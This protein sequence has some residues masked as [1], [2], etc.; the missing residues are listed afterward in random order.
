MDD[1]TTTF[2]EARA[3]VDE[4]ASRR[5]WFKFHSPKAVAAALAIE[6]AELQQVFLWLDDD[7]CEAVEYNTVDAADE[8]ADVTIYCLNMARALGVDLAAAIERKMTKNARK[9]PAL[10]DRDA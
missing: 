2:A 4:F 3:A 8:L 7:Q 1:A 9:Y 6:A 10:E 5:D